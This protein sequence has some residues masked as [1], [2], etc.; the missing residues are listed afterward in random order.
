MRDAA[1]RTPQGPGTNDIFIYNLNEALCWTAGLS[2]V[3]FVQ[4]Q[5]ISKNN[6]LCCIVCDSM[7]TLLK[8]YFTVESLIVLFALSPLRCS[9]HLKSWYTEL[10]PFEII[11][12][13]TLSSICF[14]FMS[15]KSKRPPSAHVWA[16]GSRWGGR[17]M[18]SIPVW[19]RKRSPACRSFNFH[20]LYLWF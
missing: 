19:E 15:L 3:T 10:I 17:L 2:T 6:S 8:D 9:V 1:D 4:L 20:D 7:L 11:Q 5:Q 14:I 12:L 18:R 13:W 16:A